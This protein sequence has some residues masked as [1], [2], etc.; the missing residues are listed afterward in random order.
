MAFIC[1]K[2]I[3]TLP[4]QVNQ[5]L[6]FR[7]GNDDLVA[8]NVLSDYKSLGDVEWLVLLFLNFFTNT[9]YNGVVILSPISVFHVIF[10]NLE[11]YVTDMVR[12]S[13][14]NMANYD[15]E[16]LYTWWSSTGYRENTSGV[17]CLRPR[18][19]LRGKSYFW[20]HIVQRVNREFTNWHVFKN[21]IALW[22]VTTVRSA[23][24]NNT[25]N[26]CKQTQL[27]MLLFRWSIVY[28]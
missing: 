7:L 20:I 2:M 25:R 6:N 10:H 19:Y 13:A 28:F 22:S 24:S 1:C 5:V 17:T 14:F 18:Q 23:P 26:C 15:V 21:V 4:L 12:S 8:G 27:L 11:V 16:N 9:T 3:I